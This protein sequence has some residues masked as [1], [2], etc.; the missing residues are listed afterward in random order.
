M[1]TTTNEIIDVGEEAEVLTILCSSNRIR[2]YSNKEVIGADHS[3]VVGTVISLLLLL[4]IRI[5]S[6]HM[7][8]IIL[9]YQLHYWVNSIIQML[10]VHLHK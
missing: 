4:N 7:T 2:I 9:P 8:C 3:V 5:T 1:V 6:K 10:E